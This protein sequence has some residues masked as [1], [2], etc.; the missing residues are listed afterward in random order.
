MRRPINHKKFGA[1]NNRKKEISGGL[2]IA[3]IYDVLL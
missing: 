2:A 3:T 1:N